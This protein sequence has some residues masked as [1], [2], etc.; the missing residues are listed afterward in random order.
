MLDV[1]YVS[2]AKMSTIATLGMDV[3][4]N[5]EAE[6]VC[7]KM[8]RRGEDLEKPYLFSEKLEVQEA[9][10]PIFGRGDG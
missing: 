10:N 6:F 5:H 4:K 1:Y 7:C 9:K 2:Q 3:R 8:M